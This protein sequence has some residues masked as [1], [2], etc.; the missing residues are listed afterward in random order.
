MNSKFINLERVSVRIEVI[1]CNADGSLSYSHEI[2]LVLENAI[3]ISKGKPIKMILSS[4][5]EQQAL[6]LARMLIDAVNEKY[7]HNNKI[8]SK[9]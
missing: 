8:K 7:E 5:T 9:F 6:E 3:P 1:P 4:M 2:M